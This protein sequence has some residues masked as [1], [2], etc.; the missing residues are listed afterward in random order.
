MASLV[1][2]A[3]PQ[4]EEEK[5]FVIDFYF[6]VSLFDVFMLFFMISVKIYIKI[7]GYPVGQVRPPI[8]II[9]QNGEIYN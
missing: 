3:E 8:E 5:N 4:K 2:T 6:N 1:V 9:N 7:W